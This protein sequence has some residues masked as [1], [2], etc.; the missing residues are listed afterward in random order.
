[1]YIGAL[2]N[3]PERVAEELRLPHAAFAVFGL[4]VGRP[5]P[6]RP[7]SIKPRL[8]QRAVL[9]YETYSTDDEAHAVARYDEAMSAFQQGQGMAV[10]PWSRQASQRVAGPDSLSGR[11]VLAAALRARGFPL[12]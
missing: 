12:E 6:S 9:H 2:R 7:A 3:Q 8:A 1:M 11:D 10:Q 4:C 5:D